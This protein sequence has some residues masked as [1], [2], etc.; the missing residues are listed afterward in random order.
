MPQGVKPKGQ[1]ALFDELK[2]KRI[3]Y[4]ESQLLAKTKLL[5]NKSTEFK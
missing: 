4:L 3:S 2:R 1:E 5:R